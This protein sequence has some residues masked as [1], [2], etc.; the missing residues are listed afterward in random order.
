M[1]VLHLLVTSGDNTHFEISVD[2]TASGTITLPT[3]TYT[4]NG[5]LAFY[6][7]NSY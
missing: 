5:D 7:Q 6:L 3:N 1:T 2:G 4:S